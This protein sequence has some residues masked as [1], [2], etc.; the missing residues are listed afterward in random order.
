[1]KKLIIKRMNFVYGIITFIY[2]FS[3]NVTPEFLNIM[4]SYLNEDEKSK[5]LSI[6]YTK[7]MPKLKLTDKLTKTSKLEFFTIEELKILE[8]KGYIIKDSFIKDISLIDNVI[9]EVEDMYQS[10]FLKQAYMSKGDNRWADKTFRGDY[11]AWINDKEKIS[12]VYPN[13]IYVLNYIDQLRIELNRE[14][15][16]NGKEVSVSICI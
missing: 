13:L 16:F 9:K 14:T 3:V 10:G 4:M 12:L 7:K 6:P 11:Q 5:L 1:M 15:D 2:L 8:S